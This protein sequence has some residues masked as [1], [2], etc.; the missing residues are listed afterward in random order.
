[1]LQYKYTAERLYTIMKFNLNSIYADA[2]KYLEC[3]DNNWYKFHND[4]A[5]VLVGVNDDPE[6]PS[7]GYLA[8]DMIESKMAEVVLSGIE[9]E[10][11][12]DFDIDLTEDIQR[13]IQKLRNPRIGEYAEEAYFGFW[14]NGFEFVSLTPGVGRRITVAYPTSQG[15]AYFDRVVGL[16]IRPST[17]GG[18]IMSEVSVR[19]Y[20]LA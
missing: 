20:N 8:I 12:Q 11:R 7:E 10:T 3:D 14:A 6:N 2:V 13:M 15:L 9:M 4:P 1:M 19:S 17:K 16:V 5:D 18:D